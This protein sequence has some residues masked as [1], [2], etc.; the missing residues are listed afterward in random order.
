MLAVIYLALAVCL[1]DFLCRQFYRFVSVFHRLGAAVLVGL[2]VSSWF[3]Y[4]GGLAF[5]SFWRPLLWGDALFFVTAIGGTVLVHMETQT[6]EDEAGRNRESH[7]GQLLFAA[8]KRLKL[9]R[10]GAYR[11][12]RSSRVLD[13]VCLV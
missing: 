5:A 13:D 10:L 1:G 4:L 8:P 11:R 6:F 9:G 3:T 12:I 7:C 2:L